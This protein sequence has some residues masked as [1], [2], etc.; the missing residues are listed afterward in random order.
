MDTHSIVQEL[1]ALLGQESVLTKKED[2]ICY[3]FDG[4]ASLKC[5]PLAVVFPT[6]TQ[7]VSVT[8]QLASKH[9]VGIS[10]RGSGTGLSGGSVPAENSI[11]I[12][13]GRMNR[14]L[15]YDQENLTL[16][17]EPGLV[18]NR[19]SETVEADGLFYPPDP[20]SMKV[21]TIG[22]NV[23]N[24]SGGLRG[25]KYGVTRDYI[26]GLEVVLANGEIAWLGS[27]CVKDVAGYSL[28]DL[29]I[30]S[31]G[32]LGII[33]KV[34]L[35]LIPKPEARKTLLALYDS[36]DDAAATVSKI[37]SSKIIPCTLEFIDQY[38]LQ[39]VEDFAQIG[40]PTDCG[41]VL[42]METDGFPAQV[43][44]ETEQ[45]K[46]IALEMR[47][48]EV[49]IAATKEE[50]V[51]LATARRSA[52][53]A[54]ARIRPTTILEDVTVPRDKLVEMT[55]FVRETA[56]RHNVRIANYGHF[57]DGNLH[58]TIL[59][60]ER[61]EEEMKRVHHAMDDLITKTIELKGTITGEHGIGLAKKKYLKEQFQDHSYELL[62]L[63]KRSFDPNNLLNP[64]KIF[65]A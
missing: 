27:K 32:T 33:T 47:A 64:G 38:T 15:E 36:M 62:K 42:L 57:G 22:G 58:P 5:M 52:F 17:V 4:T 18:T 21:S 59:A 25:L 43:E 11:V 50:G 48:R 55:Q 13:T 40:L 53:A 1:I 30:G 6:T 14:I 61:D 35:K 37:I 60:D 34:L 31:E 23:A 28:K 49:R 41:A 46:S 9:Q 45:M 8:I 44:S 54:V 19:I 39:C 12:A 26:M 51:A 7:E 65:D 2:L 10:T 56:A 29:F 63:V 3:S 20:S 24:N 16:L